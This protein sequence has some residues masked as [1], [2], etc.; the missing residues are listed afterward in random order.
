MSADLDQMRQKLRRELEEKAYVT[1]DER[2]LFGPSGKEFN[3]FLDIKGI[4]FKPGTLAEVS[5]IFW[6]HL[7]TQGPLQIG[8]LETVAIALMTGV[9][10]RAER[11]GV[12]LNSFYIRKSRKRDGM[13]RDVEGML[14]DEPVVLIDDALNSGKSI[15]RQ[16]EALK[17]KGKKVVEVCVIVAFRDPSF[18]QYFTDNG[19]RVWSIF[20]LDD[21]P[22][23]GGLRS[24]S[25]EEPAPPR[26]PF[27]VDWKF[28][29][30][31]TRY[32]LVVQ[33]SAPVADDERVY[34]GTDNGSMWA[35]NQENGSVVWRH[36]TLRG[37]GRKRILSSPA[38]YKGTIFFGAYDGNFYA[39]DAKTGAK[40]W[41]YFEADW[42][43]SSPCVAEDLGLVY[44]GLEFGL[45]RKHGGLAALDATTGEKKWSQPMEAHVHSSP[46]YSKKLGLVAVGSMSG[47]VSC[48]DARS[49]D[50]RWSYK[51]SSD[52]KGGLVFDDKRGLVIFGSWDD[53]IH[54][55]DVRTG[56]RV[57]SLHTFKPI[58]S[59]PM[60]WNDKL[61]MGLLDKR[62][63][64]VDLDTA[65]I[66]WQYQT[67]SRVFATPVII[68]DTLYC[69]SN[70]GR[71][72]LLDARTGKEISYFQ[73][74]ERIVNKIAFNEKTGRVFLPTYA[75]EMYGLSPIHERNV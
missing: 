59:N 46:A 49:G 66:V 3:W 23:T 74:N 53:R 57:R 67:H 14:T 15:V 27:N 69:G 44:V 5:E 4:L 62:I 13:Q 8:G 55:V 21:L 10:M 73:V 16:V 75:S 51:E 32:E 58:Y 22:K 52:V 1:K 26:I 60:I 28:E 35:L 63:V 36:E 17:A 38:L 39:L 54:M 50:K 71:L 12:K 47:E 2:E 37:A 31:G 34:F 43:G 70:D 25:P 72:Y 24:L 6:E 33:K 40:K 42:I 19:I 45:W 64:C 41:I 11:D 48:F 65:E 56:T 7:K 9:V 29:T 68:G 61:Y 30:D 20:S 18:Y